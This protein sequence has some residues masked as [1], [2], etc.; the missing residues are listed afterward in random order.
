MWEESVG[1]WGPGLAGCPERDR[2]P[3]EA[4]RSAP[5][6]ASG[7]G[8]CRCAPSPSGARSLYAIAQ[9]G[10][11]H[12]QFAQTAGVQPE[13]D[14]V[15]GHPASRIPA[16]GR[17]TLSSRP[18]AAGPKSVWERGR[19]PSPSTARPCGGYTGGE[20]PGV[21]LVAAYAGREWPGTGTIGGSGV[22]CK[23]SELG[24][25]LQPAFPTGTEEAGWSPGDALYCPAGVEPEGAGTGWGLPLGAEGQPARGK[26]GGEPA[27]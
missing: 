13:A 15:R 14:P 7:P 5:S 18:W 26:G 16:L 1:D 4:Q 21:R 2:G 3:R 12:P 22:A 11:E 9:W 6:P 19:P 25:G 20:L 24:T 8:P 10:R 27:L 17:R 23:G